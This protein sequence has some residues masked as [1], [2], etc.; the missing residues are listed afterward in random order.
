MKFGRIIVNNSSKGFEKLKK[1]LHKYYLPPQYVF[2]SPI[3]LTPMKYKPLP[4]HMWE[5]GT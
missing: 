4:I 3:P 2:R 1:Y 5:I